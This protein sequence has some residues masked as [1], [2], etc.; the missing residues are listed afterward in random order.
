MGLFK[1]V[2]CSVTIA[3]RKDV[4]IKNSALSDTALFLLW[5][6]EYFDSR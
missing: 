4:H 5:N 6:M 3:R 2:T 1:L